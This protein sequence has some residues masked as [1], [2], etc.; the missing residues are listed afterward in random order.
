M[1]K[2]LVKIERIYKKLSKAAGKAIEKGRYNDCMLYINA[3]ANLAY[4]Y[5]WIFTDPFLEDIICTLASKIKRY[6]EECHITQ[7]CVFYDAFSMDNRGLTQQYIRALMDNEIPFLYMTENVFVE[8]TDI[9]KELLRYKHA[10]ICI[11]SGRKSMS[12]S[13]YIY[14]RVL[15]YSPCKVFMHLKPW[16]V[17]A[18]VAFAALPGSIVKY[19][20]NLTDHAFWLGSQIL[21]YNIEFRNYGCSLSIDRRN[22]KREQL[23]LLPYY[24]IQNQDEFIGFPMEKKQSD[25][26]LFSGANLYKIYGNDHEFLQMIKRI[27]DENPNAYFFFAGGGDAGPFLSFVD[28]NK[29]GDRIF[30]LG[31]RRDI[32]QVVKNIDI[33]IDTFPMS[34]GLMGEY[35]MVNR[36]PVLA[37]VPKSSLGKIN[38]DSLASLFPPNSLRYFDNKEALLDYAKILITNKKEREKEGDRNYALVPT[39][40]SFGKAFLQMIST[41]VSP[42]ELKIDLNDSDQVVDR[43]LDLGKITLL[44]KVT[45]IKILRLR[46]LRIAPSYL[47]FSVMFLLS[48]F[49]RKM[50]K[51]YLL[52]RTQNCV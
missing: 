13:E 17:E 23:L 39:R 50:L 32:D 37:F 3:A 14:R 9:Y 12:M 22:L 40:E 45:L 5:N 38:N 6:K 28:K 43:Y 7:K 21:N 25:V 24:P 34:G 47:P 33:Y 48:T 30:Y 42:N 51:N 46:I 4:N 26:F 10:E 52:R 8:K 27:L 20:I 16:S 44:D 29:L 2:E 19:N 35:A 49:G 36:K 11:V 31:F 41:N 18:L 1:R 15:D